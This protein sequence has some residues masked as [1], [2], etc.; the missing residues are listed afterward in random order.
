MVAQTHASA[1]EGSVPYIAP[2][3]PILRLSE[4]VSGI[5]TVAGEVD[6][7]TAPR[8]EDHLLA[9]V[10]PIRLDLQAVTF[11]DGS[12]V[13]ALVR[14]RDQCRRDGRSFSVDACSPQVAR[15]FQT[16]GLH[17]LLIEIEDRAQRVP[18]TSCASSTALVA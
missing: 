18:A 10:G 1:R 15:L 9:L 8:F 16:L 4:P 7:D 6:I 12:G 2:R 5:V 3:V 14:M 11:I 13:R 17:D